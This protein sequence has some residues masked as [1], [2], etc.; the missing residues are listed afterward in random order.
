ME[1][2]FTE[3]T[4]YDQKNLNSKVTKFEGK[5]LELWD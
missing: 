4:T 3:F 1:D 5:L 2:N